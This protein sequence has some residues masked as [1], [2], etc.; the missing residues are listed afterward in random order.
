MLSSFLIFF[1]SMLSISVQSRSFYIFLHC[2]YYV[3]GNT[4]ILFYRWNL[5][6]HIESPI[7]ATTYFH[8]FPF[9]RKRKRFWEY[10]VCVVIGQRPD[11]RRDGIHRLWAFFP[12]ILYWFHPT[13]KFVLISNQI[14]LSRECYFGPFVFF[15]SKWKCQINVVCEC[16]KL[17]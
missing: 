10:G 8:G 1:Y 5:S 7:R 3:R 9:V 17:I 4:L 6:A 14:M 12:L 15:F 2:L 13:F 16:T 11:N